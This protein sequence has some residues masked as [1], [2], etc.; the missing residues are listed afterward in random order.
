M[1]EINKTKA[2]S[3]VQFINALSIMVEKNVSQ[4][5]AC[6]DLTL[7]YATIKNRIWKSKKLCSL[8]A[9]AGV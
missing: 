3:D 8:P 1:Q 5:D 7:D 2:V 6:A 9:Q 4:I